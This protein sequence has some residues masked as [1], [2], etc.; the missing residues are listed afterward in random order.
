MTTMTVNSP[1][2][3][4][5]F[6]FRGTATPAALTLAAAVTAGDRIVMYVSAQTPP[7]GGTGGFGGLNP[8]VSTVTSS[9]ALTWTRRKQQ[10]VVTSD[11]S[12]LVQEIWYADSVSGNGASGLAITVT[13]A[14]GAET[15]H[16]IA[17]SVT[18]STGV[19]AWDSNAALPATNTNTTATGNLPNVGSISTTSAVSA[20]LYFCAS[21]TTVALT[22]PAGYTVLEDDDNASGG[23]NFQRSSCGYQTF[24]SAQTGISITAS[25]N[26]TAHWIAI[27]D[28]LVPGA[29]APSGTWGSTEAKDTFAG[30]GGLLGGSWHS[31]EAKDTF[32]AVS[33]PSGI[34][35]SVE[36]KD[37]WT[38]TGYPK[39]NVVMAATETADI[40]GM[41][42]T[43]TQPIGLDGHATGG[44]GGVG[45]TSGTVT[46]TTTQPDDVIVINILSGG[47]F[48]RG[49]PTSITDTAGLTWK[50]RSHRQFTNDGSNL[51]QFS[52]DTWWAH[53]P[54]A[55]SGDV[56]TV[57]TPA[58]GLIAI[59]AFGVSGANFTTPWDRH[60]G[61]GL[62]KNSLQIGVSGA[63]DAAVP[64]YTNVSRVF[65]FGVFAAN[66]NTDGTTTAP[67]TFLDTIFETEGTSGT[68]G[69]I[70]MAYTTFNTQQFGTASVDFF[71]SPPPI[72]SVGDYSV[73]CD[74]IVALGEVG[75][76]DAIR[77]HF[78]G[79]GNHNIVALAGSGNS[80]VTPVSTF[81]PNSV[82]CCA[83][84][85]EGAGTTGSPTVNHVSDTNST[86][87]W[88]RRGRIT[89]ALGTFVLELWYVQMPIALPTITSS[90]T[91]V[92][93]NVSSGDILS[94]IVFAINGPDVFLRG[95][96]F[97]GHVSLP[98]TNHGETAAFQTVG[99]FSTINLNVLEIAIGANQS[100]DLTGFSELP[101]LPLKAPAELDSATPAFNIALQYKFSD[102]V[103]ANDNA[104]YD[105]SPRADHWLMLAD[106]LPV[107]PPTPPQGVWASVETTD[108]TGHTLDYT[109]IGIASPGGWVGT[110]PNH[111]VMAAVEAK[112]RNTNS[113]AFV[114]LFDGN[115]WIAAVPAHAAWASTEAKDIAS[116]HAWIL[117]EPM[118]GRWGSREA[119]D[120][121]GFSN[122]GPAVTAVMAAREAGDRLS[123]TAL[124]I[125]T[126]VPAPA[127]K[128][129][130]LIVT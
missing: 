64:V 115:G 44:A 96:L 45:I 3:A 27:A 4:T 103:V 42:G 76:A 129:N 46:L 22:T 126:A 43:V 70:A 83:V 36:T 48:N 67:F 55:L 32:H 102:G 116:W 112:D 39:L 98:A 18:S 15:G 33:V 123:A 104:A 82:V 68:V 28:A 31:T 17:F 12:T 122:R 71:I 100:T 25:A 63:T 110:K 9:P 69:H 127:R 92:C 13:L 59:E 29:G 85:I 34:W 26:T 89:D 117:G 107:G 65:S 20:I 8:T 2:M 118:V 62:L 61:S 51:P 94:V 5:G 73:Y 21:T 41:L 49:F 84:V 105:A 58:T 79:A 6:S 74:S 108:R 57:H 23:A 35:A 111:A 11:G 86:S 14:N 95:E 30:A 130:V 81:D 16:L 40:A 37:H 24:A 72:N 60:T 124:L 91:V 52:L 121:L 66:G 119:P 80:V 88:T 75:T 109:A 87:G 106:A 120:R 56:I 99:P 97:D 125:P 10:S 128:R 19:V 113:G 101:W 114:P 93:D 50:K 53:A 38:A 7:T 78:D 1:S 47:F 54:T 90:V 77:W